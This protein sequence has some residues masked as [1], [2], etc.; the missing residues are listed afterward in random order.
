MISARGNIHDVAADLTSIDF[1][2]TPIFLQPDDELGI[3]LAS[4]LDLEIKDIQSAPSNHWYL[5]CRYGDLAICH[6]NESPLV[7]SERSIRSK[8]DE[9]RSTHL[10]KACMARPGRI[11]LDAFGG[12]GVDGFTLS[13]LG[14][15]VTILEVN[16]L[17]C[18]MARHLAQELGCAAKI[19]CVDAE[20]YLQGTDEIFDVIYFDP[21]FPVH[22]KSAKPARRMQ[23]LEMMARKV[24]DIDQVIEIAKSRTRD[25]IVVK[26]RRSEKAR[27]LVPDWTVYGRTVRFEVYQTR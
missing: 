25:R 5:G 4:T 13:A 2:R 1:T 11:V 16:P 3:E 27:S 15:E 9:A 12:W 21:M 20:R 22:P 6:S 26:R 19:V 8:I 24:S 23:V 7:I 10:A 18:T 14:C 17:I